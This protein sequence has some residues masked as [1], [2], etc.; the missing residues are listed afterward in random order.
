MIEVCSLQSVASA[1]CGKSETPDGT[2][3]PIAVSP[4]RMAAPGT[5]G[6]HG[7]RAGARPPSIRWLI[8]GICVLMARSVR[9]FAFIFFMRL[10]TWT[11]TVLSHMSSIRRR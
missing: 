7:A 1:W 8:R 4:P 11:F 5:A 10:R 6:G 3:L 2:L 9:F